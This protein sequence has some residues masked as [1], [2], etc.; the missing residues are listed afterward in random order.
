MSGVYSKPGTDDIVLQFVC[1]IT[2]GKMALND[3]ANK[4]KYFVFTD[5]PSNTVKRQI[6]RIKDVLDNQNI[7]HLK[8]QFG[9]STK[10]LIKDGCL[11]K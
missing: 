3:E 9:K 7:L 6:P 8:E 4:I 2:G 5:I 1:K 10:E 11:Q